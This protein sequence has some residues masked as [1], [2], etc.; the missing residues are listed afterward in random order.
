MEFKVI[1]QNGWEKIVKVGRA[2]ARIGSAPTNDICLQSSVIAP[3]HLQFY[4]SPDSIS[5]CRVLNLAE[6]VVIHGDEGEN[7]LQTYEIIDLKESDAIVLGEYRIY[8]KFPLINSVLSESSSIKANFVLESAIL[9]PETETIG[10]LTIKNAG[11]LSD[12]QFQIMISGLPSD[13]IDI[14][15]VPL[16]FSGAQEEVRVRFFHRKLYPEFG[17][18]KLLINVTAPGSY[19]GEQTVIQQ[20]I[21][22]SPVLEH[23]LEVFDDLMNIEGSNRLEI[24]DENENVPLSIPKDQSPVVSLPA[25]PQAKL[26]PAIVESM[27]EEP[28]VPSSPEPPQKE[29]E[30]VENQTSGI[31]LGVDVGEN[32]TEPSLQVPTEPEVQKPKIARMTSDDFWG[33]D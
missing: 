14:D 28:K 32:G 7:I 17:D 13:C 27:P 2:T 9:N 22:V 5:S 30:K 23:S 20:G 18:K 8:Y 31:T 11:L 6:N 3:I 15:P 10:W 16:L 26:K 25:S 12:C 24:V 21:Y 1:E 29:M 4:V 19:L 33:E